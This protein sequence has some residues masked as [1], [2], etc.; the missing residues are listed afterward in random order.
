[1]LTTTTDIFGCPRSVY[2]KTQEIHAPLRIDA[3]IHANVQ[4]TI[5]A[6]PNAHS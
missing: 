2:D 3:S 5:K 4:I 1:M 6:I